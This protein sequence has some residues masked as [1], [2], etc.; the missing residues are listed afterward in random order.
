[1]KKVAVFL[2]AVAVVL[3]VSVNGVFA[4]GNGQNGNKPQ[5]ILLDSLEK[6]CEKAQQN[7]PF[8]EGGELDLIILGE[9]G[10]L[11][12]ESGGWMKIM[13][14]EKISVENAQGILSDVGWI[15]SEDGFLRHAGRK[16]VRGAPGHA[17]YV[18]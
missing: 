2:L 1:M 7:L 10:E 8:C 4:Q 11:P 12:A 14:M 3:G 9:D 13:S 18:K 16:T 5:L 17:D 6:A 15:T